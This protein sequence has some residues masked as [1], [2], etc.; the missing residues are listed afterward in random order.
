MVL[1]LGMTLSFG[2]G[3]GAVWCAEGV[4]EP[5]IGPQW[6]ASLSSRLARMSRP[7]DLRAIGID[8]RGRDRRWRRASRNS[9]VRNVPA[10]CNRPGGG[11]NVRAN[12]TEGL[13][14]QLRGVAATFTYSPS[15]LRLT[16]L[17]THGLKLD[18]NYTAPGTSVQT[19]H[20]YDVTDVYSPSKS[21][22]YVY[23]RWYRLS[24]WW[25][26]NARTDPYDEKKTWTYDRYNNM[27]GVNYYQ[28]INCPD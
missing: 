18:Y 8:C 26:S 12:V 24:E 9:V 25:I 11:R 16:R 6:M 23:D 14:F 13:C 7:M 17:E 3:R 4:C 15:T 10:S 20:I 2:R 22:H 28:P 21:Q 27:T 19:G 5:T 1:D